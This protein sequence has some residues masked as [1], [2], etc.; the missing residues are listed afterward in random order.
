[1]F[2]LFLNRLGSRVACFPF[3]VA[4][5]NFDHLWNIRREIIKRFM[6]HNLRLVVKRR[7]RTRSSS[8]H[9]NRTRWESISSVYYKSG[10][11]TIRYGKPQ[12]H[13][14]MRY[15]NRI[16][17][18][19]QA[20]WAVAGRLAAS[21][22]GSLAFAVSNCT[23]QKNCKIL[24]GA[25]HALANILKFVLNFIVQPTQIWASRERLSNL[26]LEQ[27]SRKLS[28]SLNSI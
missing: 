9:R 16:R 17:H 26:N 1:M 10:A 2:E 20:G 28:C 23:S 4:T 11:W 7:F 18:V 12:F 14:Q 5:N 15:K 24:I 13:M 19:K 6:S 8:H 3:Q 22:E 25:F 27:I 21:L